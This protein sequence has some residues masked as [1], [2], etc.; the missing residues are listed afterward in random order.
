MIEKYRIEFFNFMAFALF[1]VFLTTVQSSLWFKF[2]SISLTPHFWIILIAYFS[3]LKPSF[4]SIVMIYLSSFFYSSLSSMHFGKILCFQ[5]LIFLISWTGQDLLNLKNKKIFV[6][7][8]F[9][10]SLLLPLYD[11][12]LSTIIP[13]QTFSSYTFLTWFVSS[14]LMLPFASGLYWCFKKIDL[15][16]LE[17]KNPLE[18]RAQ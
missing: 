11:W 9:A 7:F 17:L 5:A 1:A 3:I 18:D 2:Q 6:L 10:Y 15:F 4:Q 14:I 13:I 8:C 16:F 12:I